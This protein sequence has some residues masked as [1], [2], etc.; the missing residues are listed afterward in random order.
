MDQLFKSITMYNQ[1]IK[2]KLPSLHSE[3][4]LIKWLP[5]SKTKIHNHCGKNCNFLLLKGSLTETRY[6]KNN[7]IESNEIKAFQINFIN[8]ELG[9]HEIKNN[10]DQIKW[11]LH[12]YS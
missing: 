1:Y 7:E 3:I 9:K 11:S 2:Y 10:D 8:D 6:L 12:R 4:Y 5:N